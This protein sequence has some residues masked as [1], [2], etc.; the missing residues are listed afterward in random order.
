[1]TKAEGAVRLVPLPVYHGKL[2]KGLSIQ[3]SVRL[4]EVTF[5]SVCEGR[6]GVFLLVAEGESVAGPVL[7]I[8]NTNS[9]YRFACGARQFMNACL[10][11]ME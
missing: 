2:G 8:G 4:G 9:R 5:L 11:R 10:W 6:D 7:N 3:M 1:M